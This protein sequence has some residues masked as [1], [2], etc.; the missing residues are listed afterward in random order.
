[1]K[2]AL[3]TVQFGLNYGVSNQY[4][5]PNASEIDKILS[6]ASQNKITLLDTASGYGNSHEQLKRQKVYQRGFDLIT[7]LPPHCKPTFSQDDIEHY[8]T[9]LSNTFDELGTSNLTGLL[10]HQADDL[11]KD[12]I[13]PLL[14]A[15]TKLKT[16][17][18]IKNIGISVYP[19]TPLEQVLNTYNFDIIQL[20]Y[21]LL[22]RFF[23]S[24]GWLNKLS[25]KG[26]EIHARSL[27]LQGLLLMRKADY[28]D[29]F[30]PWLKALNKVDKIAKHLN[31][32]KL[33]LCL[34]YIE[35]Q[36]S[37]SKWIIGVNLA[38]ELEEILRAYE[39]ALTLA[40]H[41]LPDLSVANDALTNPAQWQL[42]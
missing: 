18:R 35:Q 26:I 20:P 39:V 16:E 1:M 30:K 3:G 25:N 12:N 8:L 29:Y 27:F 15:L 23:E 19:N 28:P 21:N 31:V 24:S 7:K 22:D 42:S 11:L 37:I 10:F 33:A 34:A 17:N 2:I 13:A 9:L 40:K 32:S 4:G 5:Q 14:K 38:S 6:L 36:K 41:D